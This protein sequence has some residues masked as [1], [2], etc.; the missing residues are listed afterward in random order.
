MIKLKPLAESNIIEKLAN[1]E[2]IQWAHWTEYM[3]NNLTD[4]NINRWKQQI[5]TSYASLS[6]K[7]KESDREWARKALEILNEKN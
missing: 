5:K 2:H 4:E 3:L 7:E 6:E 1:L